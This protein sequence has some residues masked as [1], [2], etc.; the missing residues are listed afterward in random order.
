MSELSIH[1]RITACQNA[2]QKVLP[3]AAVK[4]LVLHRT[5]LHVF[6]PVANPHPIPDDLLDGPAL[7]ARFKNKGLGTGGI[8]PYHFLI[9][10]NTPEFAVEQILPLSLRGAHAAGYNWQSYGIACV[11]DFR[12]SPVPEGMW[13][14]LCELMSLLIP[15][16]GGLD[17]AGHSDLPGACPSDPN[18]V[19]PGTHLSPKLAA[20][21]AMNGLPPDWR[22][23]T[24][25]DV[26]ARLLAAGIAL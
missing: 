15:I 10:A 3:Q 13:L 24:S 11:G 8:T 9:R 23:W 16:N 19:C 25:D 2:N 22:V 14:N 5:D 4:M 26:N 17:A 6:D 20:A 1:N 7:A 12:K 21:Q 18:K